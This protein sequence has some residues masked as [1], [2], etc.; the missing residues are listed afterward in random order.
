[1][2]NE[3]NL[4]WL[5]QT[6]PYTKTRWA[7]LH[8]RWACFCEL[9]CLEISTIYGLQH[10]CGDS[11]NHWL[12]LP[13][14]NSKGLFW[15]SQF[16][17]DVG[18]RKRLAIR[19]TQRTWDSKRIW[20]TQKELEKKD[21]YMEAKLTKG[22]HNPQGYWHWLAAIKKL[23]VAAKVGEEQAKKS[24]VLATPLVDLLAC[25][26]VCS[27]AEILCLTPTWLIKLTFFTSWHSSKGLGHQT[28]G[29]TLT[30][31]D[32]ASCFKE[33][34]PLTSKNSDEVTKAFAKIYRCSPLEWSKML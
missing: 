14:L 18:S 17:S 27:L 33:A 24:L 7:C 21:L 31:V 4:F 2:P 25:P 5:L 26:Y 22:Y 10:I 11:E 16:P 28:F 12:C 34:E 29:Y 8:W 13:P 1:M 3:L 9:C 20:G 23:A 32:G 15:T 6:Q 30:V 19:K